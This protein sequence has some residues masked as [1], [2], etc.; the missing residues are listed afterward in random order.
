MTTMFL[1]ARPATDL[2]TADVAVETP[3]SLA[4]LESPAFVE[5]RRSSGSDVAPIGRE[6]RQFASSHHDLSPEG[7]RLA[8]AI[9]RYKLQRRRRFITTDE[10]LTVLVDLGYHR[11]DAV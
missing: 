1:P 3:P 7:R 2:T 9:D 5:R 4:P 11:P 6:R 8:E 10:L